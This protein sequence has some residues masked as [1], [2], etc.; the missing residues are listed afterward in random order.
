MRN[1]ISNALK[2]TKSEGRIDI[3][4]ENPGIT[5]KITVQDSG[6]G[7]SKEVR[8]SLFTLSN[9]NSAPGL[10]SE[11]GHGIGL[12]LCHKQITDL[13]GTIKVESKQGEGTSF[14]VELP[15]EKIN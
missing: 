7:M 12:Y 1:L 4:L 13:G 6:V 9:G 3:R 14:I 15:Q 10:R 8:E 2:F 5:Y 11:R